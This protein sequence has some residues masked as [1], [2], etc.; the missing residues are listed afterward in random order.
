MCRWS[1]RGV[2]LLLTGFVLAS[3]AAPVAAQPGAST[4]HCSGVPWIAVDLAVD[5]EPAQR[6]ALLDHL[7]AGFDVYGLTVCETRGSAEPPLARVRI[8]Q[9]DA[10][11]VALS[12]DVHDAV[13]HKR[14]GRDVDVAGY[15]AEGQALAIA[16]AAEELVRASWVELR[17][18]ERPAAPT[19]RPPPPE[20]ERVVADSVP[21]RSGRRTSLVLRGASEAYSG[22]QL[23]WGL[24][25]VLR[26]PLGSRFALGASLG[27]RQAVPERVAPGTLRGRAFLGELFVDLAIARGSRLELDLETG[28]R[29]GELSFAGETATTTQTAGGAVAIVRSG[30]TLSIRGSER[31]G[32]E[33]GAGA[34]AVVLG[35]NAS[36]RGTTLSG[37]SGAE[38]HLSLG[39]GGRL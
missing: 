37:A 2:T 24:D 27:P 1:P 15:S 3:G 10:A 11:S 36:G 38:G 14:I 30:V 8:G 26:Q 12:V 9:N 29:A 33:L 28:L 5:W 16:V 17:M 20:V 23:H 39:L 6:Q 21:E 18:R 31:W 4:E 7:R 25:L 32:L 34:G 22:G 19:T 13:T 35:A